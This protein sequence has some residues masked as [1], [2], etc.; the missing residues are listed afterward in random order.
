M[1]IPTVTPSPLRKRLDKRGG[2][3]QECPRH[4]SWP[5]TGL[6]R[7]GGKVFVVIVAI[8][9]F[10]GRTFCGSVVKGGDRSLPFF[11][12]FDINDNLRRLWLFKFDALEIGRSDLE[13]VEQN[14][15]GFLLESFLQDHLDDLANYDMNRVRILK[16]R[17]GDFAGCVWSVGIT[18]DL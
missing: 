9:V 11:F 2:R 14:A 6:D 5:I 10:A 18:F 4:T 3:G 16:Q 8:D 17:Q 13:R 7:S 1:R 12:P 15:G